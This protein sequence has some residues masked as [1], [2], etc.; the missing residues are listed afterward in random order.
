MKYQWIG[1]FWWGR[2]DMCS[3]VGDNGITVTPFDR[4]NHG[5]NENITNSISFQFKN[6]FL[7][8]D[9]FQGITEMI[10]SRTD[11]G[12]THCCRY[13]NNNTAD[14][15]QQKLI[16]I[17]QNTRMKISMWTLNSVGFFVVVVYSVGKAKV[18]WQLKSSCAYM[19]MVT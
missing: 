8:F 12:N 14:L 4:K 1:K 6:F 5:M 17:V 15:S 9:W 2:S 3:N 10:R 16:N 13:Q 7:Y 11:K 18:C 19:L